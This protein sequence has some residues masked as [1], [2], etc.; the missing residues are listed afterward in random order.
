MRVFAQVGVWICYGITHAFQLL[1]LRGPD[2]LVRRARRAVLVRDTA[3][4]G[5]KS[6]EAT[7]PAG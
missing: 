1:A 3:A 7:G 5:P 4:I 6:Q 2:L